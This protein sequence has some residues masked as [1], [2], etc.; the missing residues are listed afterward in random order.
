MDSLYYKASGKAPISGILLM[1]IGGTIAG[2][3]LSIVYIALQWFIPFIYLNLFIAIG[4]GIGT[5]MALVFLLKKGKVRNPSI[6]VAIAFIVTIISYYS[7]WALYLSLLL[8]SSGGG[9]FFVKTSFN[10]DTFL[11]EFMHPFDIM[12]NIKTLV[13]IG[14]FTLKG[15]VVKGGFLVFIWIIEALLIIAIAPIFISGNAKEPFSEL[16]DNWMEEKT[17]PINLK[18]IEKENLQNFKNELEKGNYLPLLELKNNDNPNKYAV[19]KTYSIDGDDKQF[20][21]I[22]NVEITYNSKNEEKKDETDV[23]KYLQIATSDL[24]ALV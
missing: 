11:Y 6:A 12:N 10:L 4:F 7:Q 23:V 15:S 19:L 8:Q 9:S 5:Y 13:G 16:Q 3:L 2:I 18:F 22:E 20:L 24:S 1:L 17:L 21:S 14:T